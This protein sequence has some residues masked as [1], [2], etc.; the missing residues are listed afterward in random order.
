V[1]YHGGPV[2]TNESKPNVWVQKLRQA[3]S[4]GF[5]V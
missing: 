4:E 3:S 1:I 5:R 2:I